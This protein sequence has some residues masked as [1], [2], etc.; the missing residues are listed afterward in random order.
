M[1]MLFVTWNDDHPPCQY[2]LPEGTTLEQ[3]TNEPVIL[4]SD[5]GQHIEFMLDA[6]RVR[7]AYLVDVPDNVFI[8]DLS[9]VPVA[10]LD[11]LDHGMSR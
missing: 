11:A 7:A 4:D 9:E 8:A 10:D 1:R 2:S 5:D 6:Q 3:I